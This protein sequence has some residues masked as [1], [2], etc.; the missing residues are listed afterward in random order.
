MNLKPVQK[1]PAMRL[2]GQPSDD[3]DA[4]AIVGIESFVLTKNM[5]MCKFEGSAIFSSCTH[6]S[7][8]VHVGTAKSSATQR[9][10]STG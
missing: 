2:H 9:R 4:A 6:D 1:M 7:D 8:S 10:K 3:S 5:C